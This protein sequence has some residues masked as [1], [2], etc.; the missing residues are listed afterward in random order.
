MGPFLHV[1]LQ[2]AV[3]FLIGLGVLLATYPLYL[4]LRF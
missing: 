3:A 4:I 1:L 2:L